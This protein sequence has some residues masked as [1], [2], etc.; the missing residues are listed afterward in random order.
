VGEGWLPLRIIVPGSINHNFAIAQWAGDRLGYQFTS[1]F[2]AVGITND[3]AR[4]PQ[5]C[6]AVVFNGF[7][8]ANIDLTAVGSRCWTRS[9]LC[10]LSAYVFNQLKCERVTLITRA[11]NPARRLLGKHFKFETKRKCHFGNEDG[12]QYRMCRDEC[13]WLEK[14]NG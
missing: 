13:P 5:L 4:I 12:L 1:P 3:T 8:D 10:Q 6:G 11:S 14:L 7:T 9:I 2:Y